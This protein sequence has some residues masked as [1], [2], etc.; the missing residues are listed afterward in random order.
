MR[1]SLQ[2]NVPVA[3]FFLTVDFC[4]YRKKKTFGT[5]IYTRKVG[6]FGDIREICLIVVASMHVIDE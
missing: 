4:S 6:Y 3:I 1:K 5:G 2:V